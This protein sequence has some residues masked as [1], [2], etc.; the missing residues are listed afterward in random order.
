MSYCKVKK[1]E[2]VVIGSL[3]RDRTLVKGVSQPLAFHVPGPTEIIV[4]QIFGRNV[5]KIL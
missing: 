2:L 3:V 5:Y 4:L 1:E